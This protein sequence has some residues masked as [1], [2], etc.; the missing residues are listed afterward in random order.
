MKLKVY[1]H[2]DVARL[3]SHRPLETK[4]GEAL[5]LLPQ[6]EDLSD[7]LAK[8]KSLGA[9][10]ALLGVP[11]DLGPRA[12]LGKGGAELG[13]PAFLQ[14]FLNLQSQPG[15]P[16]QSLLLLGELELN[17]LM[18]QGQE[19]SAQRPEQLAKL[20]ELVGE[21][22]KRLAPVIKAIAKA[23][24]IPIVIGGGHNNAF[25]IIQGMHQALGDPMA[26]LNIDPH[27]DFRPM[28]GRHSGNGFR[29]AHEGGHLAQYQVLAMHSWKNSAASQQ[30][31]KDAGFGFVSYQDLKVSRSTSL[32]QALEQLS[33]K[34]LGHPTG[35]ELDMDV[36]NLMPASAYTN[37]SLPLA[38]V[39]YLIHRAATLLRPRYLHLCEAAPARHPA[40]EAFGI[41][42]CGQGLAA[43][44]VAFVEA[45]VP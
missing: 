8:A 12:N 25:P 37:A 24:L 16:T 41:S 36:I 11:E 34:L 38:D 29:Y 43:M 20:R 7:R 13:W 40:G 27:A 31:L 23:G 32:E 9:R 18:A 28:E 14:R 19:L 4:V 15:F 5:T 30:A 10:F 33:R 3:I 35:L 2:S 42:D 22:D 26:V 1:T 17:D 39:E 45:M 44:V 6:G 21:V